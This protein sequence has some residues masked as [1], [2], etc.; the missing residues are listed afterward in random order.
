MPN[1]RA[2]PVLAAPLAL[3]AACGSSGGGGPTGPSQTYETLQSTAAVTTPLVGRAFAISDAIINPTPI[4]PMTGSVDLGTGAMTVG[5]YTDSDGPDGSGEIVHDVVNPLVSQKGSFIVPPGYSYLALAGWHYVSTTG[6]FGGQSGF[7]GVG[8]AAADIPGSG[9]A[10]YTGTASGTGPNG[11]WTNAPGTISAN[12]GA[13]TVAATATGVVGGV[14]STVAVN[15]MTIS[16]TGF[17]GGTA[18]TTVNGV[19]GNYATTLNTGGQFYGYDTGLNGPDEVGLLISGSG[20]D[21]GVQLTMT[22]D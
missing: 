18:T 6:F 16:G 20:T 13:G 1:L 7:L 19:A 2:L 22:A 14:T 15:G 8:T 9:S 12:F 4:G 10:T 11:T 5:P 3:L 21:G 17:G